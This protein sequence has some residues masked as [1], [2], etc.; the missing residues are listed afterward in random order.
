MT[1]LAPRH[2]LTIN[3]I[4]NCIWAFSVWNL[5][6]AFPILLL[7]CYSQ[8]YIFFSKGVLSCSIE[9]CLKFSNVSRL[10]DTNFSGF[11]KICKK[12]DLIVL[13][14]PRIWSQIIQKIHKHNECIPSSARN[15]KAVLNK[16]AVRFTLW[17][18]FA[19]ES[20]LWV[21]AYGV[22][23]LTRRGIRA[24]SNAV[25]SRFQHP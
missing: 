12:T 22:H 18:Y 6:F 24:S 4:W 1:R 23:N 11:V 13:Q 15:Y 14:K 25:P 3:C 5:C 7:Y 19:H 17:K 2:K 8:V 10:V 21:S 9:L 16:D 20:S